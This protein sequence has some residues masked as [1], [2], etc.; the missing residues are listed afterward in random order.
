MTYNNMCHNL[1]LRVFMKYKN[2][3]SAIHNFG[4]SYTNLMNYVDH[5]YFIDELNIIHHKDYDLEVA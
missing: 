3:Y 2:I 1:A 4:Y 5:D